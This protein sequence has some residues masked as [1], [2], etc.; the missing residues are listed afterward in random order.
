MGTEYS[1]LAQWRKSSWSGSLRSVEVRRVGD[2][3]QLRNSA[4]AAGAIIDL[5]YAEW[6]AFVLGVQGGE[7]AFT[8]D[9]DYAPAGLGSRP[10]GGATEPE[11]ATSSVGGSSEE[12]QASVWTSDND[13]SEIVDALREAM[14]VY[15]RTV[16]TDGPPIRG[17]WWQRLKI[18]GKTL[19]G[20]DL[21]RDSA[22]EILLRARL[23]VVA[24]TKAQVDA[25]NGET[26]TQID[27]SY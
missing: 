16:D 4:D 23:E 1:E 11:S 7:F 24:K 22:E 12:L 3:I 27:R 21:V 20:Q 13:G 17:S 6:R 14:A 19:A 26:I 2:R 5:S 25:I 15:K 9:S 10:Q 8:D 18:A